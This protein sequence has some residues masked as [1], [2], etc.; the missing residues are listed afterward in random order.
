MER[1][2]LSSIPSL[3]C[4]NCG[5]QSAKFRQ[6]SGS[7]IFQ[8][9]LS[10]K[11]KSLMTA[12]GKYF[13]PLKYPN[14]K[15]SQDFTEKIENMDFN[16]TDLLLLPIQV[17]AHLYMM[18]EQN[19][20]LF[21]LL[22]GSYDPIQKKRVSSPDVFFIEVVPVPPNRFRPMSKMGDMTYEHPQNTHLTQIIKDKIRIAD[23]LEQEK[24]ALEVLDSVENPKA[25]DNTKSDYAIKTIEALVALQNSVN[26]LIDNSKAGS[27]GGTPPPPGIR[28][29]LEKKEGL[30]RKH[31]MGKRV[32][33]AARSVISPDPYIETSEIG[34]SLFD[35][36]FIDTASICKKTYLSRACNSP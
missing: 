7:K 24:K 36:N 6:D 13:Q 31:M 33:Y 14:L 18:W 21:D 19:S 8:K 27:V 25:Y 16:D 32:N 35:L 29:I 9:P 1:Q 30:F 15:K 28:Q 17:A 20:E 22:Y 5:G 10:L 26:S 12:R 23:L 4:A 11:Q 34:V 2:V 3:A